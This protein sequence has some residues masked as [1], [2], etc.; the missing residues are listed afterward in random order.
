MKKYPLVFNGT[1]QQLQAGD[2]LHP[3]SISEV[4]LQVFQLLKL[5]VFYLVEEGFEDIPAPL[6][7]LLE[8]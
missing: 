8:E 4:D 3:S 6:L 2:T 5:L 7:T 1:L